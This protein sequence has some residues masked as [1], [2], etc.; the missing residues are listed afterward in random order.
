[1][2]LELPNVLPMTSQNG[3]AVRMT[4]ATKPV[5]YPRSVK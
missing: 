2:M 1:V 5:T 4:A 3:M